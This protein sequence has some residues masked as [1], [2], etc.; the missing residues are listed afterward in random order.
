MAGDRR[1]G[2]ISMLSA[3]ITINFDTD[4]ELPFVIWDGDGLTDAQL[5]AQIDAGTASRKDV[6][7]W[8]L[9]FAMRKKVNSADPPLITKSTSVGGIAIEGTFGG[10]P[11]QLVVV[12][13][14]DT[15]TYDP[16]SS[17]TVEIK[18][19]NYVYALKRVGAGVETVLV[20][21]TLTVHRTA[22]WE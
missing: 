21:G 14:D 15:D 10:S 4:V 17:P 12:S 1:I 22:A 16:D 2:G 20:E 8:D 3:D 9:A 6:T 18:A 5:Q 7:G 11:D 19:G 13:I